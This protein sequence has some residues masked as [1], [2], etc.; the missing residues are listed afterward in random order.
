MRDLCLPRRGPSKRLALLE[1]VWS[2]RT[3]DRSVNAP[4]TEK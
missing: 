3:V 2:R 1:Q 4:T